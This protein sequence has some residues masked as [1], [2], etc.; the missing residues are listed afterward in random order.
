MDSLERS[1]YLTDGTVDE[2]GTLFEVAHGFPDTFLPEVTHER[3]GWWARLKT[4]FGLRR[5]NPPSMP[6][7][8][9]DG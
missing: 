3:M 4:F 1:D 8:P 5:R 7:E 2:I 9:R 6:S